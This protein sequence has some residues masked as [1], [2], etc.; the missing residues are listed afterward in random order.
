MVR[1]LL[2]FKND[3]REILTA[4]LLA[5]E[6]DPQID[7]LKSSLS[8][9]REKQAEA[10][11]KTTGVLA[12]TAILGS[13]AVAEAGAI[14][15][16]AVAESVALTG[17]A[18]VGTI[19]GRQANMMT[20]G[21]TAAARGARFA[22]GLGG[23]L[24]AATILLEARTLTATIDQIRLGNPCE[25]AVALR[26]ILKEIPAFPSTQELDEECRIYIGALSN[27]MNAGSLEDAINLIERQAI[28][29]WQMTKASIKSEKK[30]DNSE[31][32]AP[33]GASILDSDTEDDDS[34]WESV[35][36]A[37]SAKI[38]GRS[39]HDEDPVPHF[40]EMTNGGNVAST[41]VGPRMA[42]SMPQLSSEN[43]DP[44]K[45][46]ALLDRIKKFKE[47]DK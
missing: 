31:E 37:L 16:V 3:L 22:R 27:R 30:I 29:E 4:R 38:K 20:K 17:A 13:V 45:Q 47:E 19:A 11:V 46:S 5:Q 41:L 40:V 26:S 10:A 25:K 42:Q 35:T 23:A 18:E 44:Q 9:L 33:E 12:S 32:L 24:S 14:G 34:V 1:S 6:G 7:R 36:G 21:A 39:A 8:K 43:F 2:K 28:Q 15:G